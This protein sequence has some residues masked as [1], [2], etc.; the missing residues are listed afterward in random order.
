MF[1]CQRLKLLLYLAE[2]WRHEGWDSIT[3]GA[4]QKPSHAPLAPGGQATS[5]TIGWRFA[6]EVGGG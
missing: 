2:R 1:M 5:D 4:L 3:E 6:E